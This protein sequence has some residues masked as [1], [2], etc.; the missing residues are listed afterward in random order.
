MKYTKKSD[1]AQIMKA[2]KMLL[3]EHGL[4]LKSYC[5]R[6]DYSY[7]ATYQKLTI[8]SIEKDLIN[9]MIHKLDP[10]RELLEINNKLV[11]ARKF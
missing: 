7:S 3:V 4:S 11:I 10:K 1:K 5:K 2:F 6:Y 8:N 9:E